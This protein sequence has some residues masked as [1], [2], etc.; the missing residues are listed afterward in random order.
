MIFDLVNVTTAFL[1]LS[2]T[3]GQCYKY[4]MVVTYDRSRNKQLCPL[5]A[6][7]RAFLQTRVA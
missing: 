2:E 6:Y 4:F 1:P 3:R 7:L 5:Q